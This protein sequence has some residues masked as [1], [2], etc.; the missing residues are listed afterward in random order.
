VKLSYFKSIP[1]QSKIYNKVLVPNNQYTR[2]LNFGKT[3]RDLKAMTNMESIVTSS[4][5]EE[6]SVQAEEKKEEVVDS[7]SAAI[8]KVLPLS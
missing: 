2:K 3:E 8:K 1:S 6:G 4:D 7:E 5:D